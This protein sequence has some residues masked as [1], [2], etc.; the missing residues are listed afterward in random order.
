MGKRAKHGQ[1][2]LRLRYQACGLCRQP[3][4]NRLTCMRKESA[5]RLLPFGVAP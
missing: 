2:K 4:H 3:D 1:Q 5:Q